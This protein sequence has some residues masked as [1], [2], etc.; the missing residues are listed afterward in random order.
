MKL[1]EVKQ[2][3]CEILSVPSAGDAAKRLARLGIA[4]G[5]RVRLLRRAPFG[6]GVL[7]EAGGARVALRGS[8]AAEIGALPAP[9]LPPSSLP[10]P[11]SSPAAAGC[12]PFP[13]RAA[14]PLP[15]AGRAQT[16]RKSVV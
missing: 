5:Q 8:I 6:G 13:G 10:S 14:R 9:P 7:L 3:D 11:P 2:G 15:R 12:P 1:S 16:D 4:A